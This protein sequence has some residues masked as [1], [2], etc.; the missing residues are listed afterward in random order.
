MSTFVIGDIHGAHKALRQCL[1]R[2]GF[3]RKKDTLI[4]LGDVA[5][6]YSDV[7]ACVEELL[8]IP[9]LIA[10]KGN[11]DEWLNQF[12]E[13]AYH[14]Q[15]WMMGGEATAR[16]IWLAFLRKP[17]VYYQLHQFLLI[18]PAHRKPVTT[19]Q[20]AI[21]RHAADPGDRYGI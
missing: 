1:E 17:A 3:D 21:G 4:Q 8:S 7:Y 20:A 6:G 5:D 18:R 19:C 12:L 14:P 10:I 13:T 15:G 16:S 2:S 11:H 9:N